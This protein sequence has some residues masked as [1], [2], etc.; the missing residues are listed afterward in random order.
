MQRQPKSV[1]SDSWLA[2][3][4][5]HKWPLSELTST[6][7][8]AHRSELFTRP[9]NNF[10]Y[11]FGS[12]NKNFVRFFDEFASFPLLPRRQRGRFCRENQ[13]RGVEKN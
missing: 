8:F 13:L 6:A 12:C 10:D 1:G 3:F 4:Q 2:L 11:S 5:L 7:L 9:G